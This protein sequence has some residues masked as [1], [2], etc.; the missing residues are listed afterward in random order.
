MID[1]DD[2]DYMDEEEVLNITEKEILSQLGE[3]R[4]FAYEVHTLAEKRRKKDNNNIVVKDQDDVFDIGAARKR[5]ENGKIVTRG[6]DD[7][8][9][10][11]N[12]VGKHTYKRK[13]LV[14]EESE[15]V[16]L[17]PV[18]PDP[19][20][21]DRLKRDGALSINIIPEDP[22]DRSLTSPIENDQLLSTVKNN[23]S[24]NRV[25]NI[26]VEE[27]A[28][29]AAYLKAWR[30]EQWCN[31]SDVSSV[32][33]KR[34]KTLKNLVDTLI[35][36]EKLKNNRA[37]AKID[38]HGEAFGRVLKYFLEVIQKTF[39]TVDIPVQYET[40]FFTELAKAFEKF[41]KKA[42]R[43]YHGKDV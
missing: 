1:D 19:D 39:H 13:K 11:A 5:K 21:S 10:V 35:E 8:F 43:L 24:I 2:S 14:K 4:D 12:D 31:G 20:K 26:V 9:D 6:E 22:L 30:N 34:I 25:M 37:V 42:E 16:L 15:D 7:V 27:L 33:F 32:T 40:I 29:E 18:P 23:K 17:P 28:E 3:V 38:F 41:E 36:Q